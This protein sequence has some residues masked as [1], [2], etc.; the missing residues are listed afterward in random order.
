MVAGFAR[1]ERQPEHE[2]T[3]SNAIELTR[4]FIERSFAT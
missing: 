4:V 2:N 1:P 3:T